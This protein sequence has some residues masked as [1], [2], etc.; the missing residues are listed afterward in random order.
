MAM[1]PSP[2]EDPAGR[3]AATLLVHTRASVVR[4]ACQAMDIVH[5]R[6]EF[7]ITFRALRECYRQ[8]AITLKADEIQS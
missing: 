6:E 3:Q 7:V 5:A 2:L 8:I 1:G 4:W